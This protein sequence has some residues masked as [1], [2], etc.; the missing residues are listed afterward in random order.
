MR[1]RKRKLG[2][3]VVTGERVMLWLQSREKG[4]V[5][6]PGGWKRGM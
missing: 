5:R 3:A 6:G 4:E 1:R 2:C